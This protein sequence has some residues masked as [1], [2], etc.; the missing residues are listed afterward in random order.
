MKSLILLLMG[1]GLVLAGG[2]VYA[3]EA[4]DL[5]SIVQDDNLLYSAS[6][7]AVTFVSA[8]EKC[9]VCKGAGGMAAGGMAAA[10]APDIRSFIKDSHLYSAPDNA[11]SFSAVIPTSIPSWSRGLAQEWEVYNG[12]TVPGGNP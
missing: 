11:V 2:L 10:A 7:N 8:I 12:V 1:L 6:D 4:P 3:D 9:T 5:R